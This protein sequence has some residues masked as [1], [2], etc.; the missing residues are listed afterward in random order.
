MDRSGE[1]LPAVSL[2]ADGLLPGLPAACCPLPAACCLLPAGLRKPA[3][4]CLL[5]A[6]CCLEAGRPDETGRLGSAVVSAVVVRA[7]DGWAGWR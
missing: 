5:P 1:G 6:A 7:E 4:C 2:P 3:A